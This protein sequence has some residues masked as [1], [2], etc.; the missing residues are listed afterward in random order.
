MSF[1]YNPGML[2][3][4]LLVLL[5]LG[6]CCF[7]QTTESPKPHAEKAARPDQ[8]AAGSPRQTD[9]A[10]SDKLE[11]IER[12]WA[13]AEVKHDPSLIAPYLADSL[14]KTGDDNQPIARQQLLERIK[15]SDTTIGSIDISDMKVQV[16]GD[17]AVV[18]GIFKAAGTSK[19]KN[20]TNTGRFTDTFVMQDGRWQ[21]V[22]SHDSLNRD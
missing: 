12:D 5:L 20:F 13:D 17:T 21:A 18:T 10:V 2:S 16:Y 4:A 6:S 8:G 1:A 14:I 15:N 11:Q 9:A 3:R 7:A 22:A 19:G